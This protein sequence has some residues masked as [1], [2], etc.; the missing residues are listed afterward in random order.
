MGSSNSRE[1][2][3]DELPTYIEHN[4]NCSSIVFQGHRI[5]MEDFVDYKQSEH[6]HWLAV[7]DGHGGD[8]CSTFLKEHLLSNLSLVDSEQLTTEAVTST[9]ILTERQFKESFQVH[10]G[11]YKAPEKTENKELFIRTPIGNSG[12]CAIVA[13]INDTVLTVA[14]TGDCACIL[15]FDDNSFEV[16]STMHRP[17][18]VDLDPESMRINGAG[19]SVMHERVNGE[20]AVSRAFGDFEYKGISLDEFGHA[21]TCVPSMYQRHLQKNE[22]YLI[23]YSD[24]LES[25]CHKEIVKI[26]TMC[27]LTVESKLNNLVSASFKDTRDNVSIMLFKF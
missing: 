12:S 8:S 4:I 24:G 17:K 26:V 5:S 20:L 27:E 19:L 1:I 23:L 25:L 16:I 15:I 6:G 3:K 10:K 7:Y 13:H 21:V 14:N 22:K 9:F 11:P 18:H 2:P